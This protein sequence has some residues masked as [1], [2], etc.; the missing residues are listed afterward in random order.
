MRNFATYAITNKTENCR[1]R[2]VYDED[3]QT[4]GSFAYDTEEETRAAEE[5][6]I[7]L[8]ESGEAVALG[9]MVEERCPHCDAWS[10]TDSLWGIVATHD[11]DLEAYASHCMPFPVQ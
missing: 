9:A 4:R 5:R 7:A 8:L 6:E 2:W 3:Y 11:E 10:V 1:V